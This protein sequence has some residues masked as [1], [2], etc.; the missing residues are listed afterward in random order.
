MKKVNL[1]LRPESEILGLFLRHTGTHTSFVF[2][3]AG[4]FDAALFVCVLFLESD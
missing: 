2:V 4:L 3:C 1:P